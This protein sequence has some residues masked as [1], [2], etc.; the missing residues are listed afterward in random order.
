MEQRQP[1]PTPTET[2]AHHALEAALAERLLH[3]ACVTFSSG[4]MA[5]L[6]AVATLAG[7]DTLIVSDAHNHASLI[8]ACRLTKAPVQIV[9]HNDTA[10]VEA[11]LAERR[12]PDPVGGHDHAERPRV[13]RRRHEIRE[14]RFGGHQVL[15]DERKKYEVRSMK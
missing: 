13:E 3:P 6:A 9:A 8:D 15:D 1:P 12:Q 7:P 11:A 2:R 10:A 5:N 4:Y 14:P